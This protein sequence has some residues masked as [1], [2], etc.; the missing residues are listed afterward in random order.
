[1]RRLGRFSSRAL[2]IASLVVLVAG[3]MPA[4]IARADNGNANLHL[5][6][7]VGAVAV[8]PGL[9]LA[10]AVDKPDAVPGT[11]LTYTALVTN[12][13]AT[14]T[15]A[16]DL[17]ATNTNATAA[18]IASYWDAISTTDKAHCGAGGT[19]DGKDTA[20]WP[21]FVGTAA[22]AA[23]YTP[24]SGAPITSGMTLVATPVA[25]AGVEGRWLRVQD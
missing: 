12:T 3:L 17:T 18:T 9:G 21:T 4:H 10:L 15:L 2:A 24:V 8:I 13:G 7:T 11:V 22:S 6:K 19:N 25:V 5:D 20:Q 23:G 1:M 14:L 16:G